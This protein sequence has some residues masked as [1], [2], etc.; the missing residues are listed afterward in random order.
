MRLDCEQR[1]FAQCITGVLGVLI[2]SYVFFF[3][4]TESYIDN[5]IMKR[6]TRS[7]SAL[8]RPRKDNSATDSPVL[9]L[10]SIYT[11]PHDI[12]KYI[13]TYISDRAR[14]CSVSVYWNELA[15]EVSRELSPVPLLWDGAMY[16]VEP[17]YS[18]LDHWTCTIHPDP[19]MDLHLA[20]RLIRTPCIYR[21]CA[22]G[23]YDIVKDLNVLTR[24]ICV[25]DDCLLM[26]I[27][28]DNITSRVDICFE[29]ACASGNTRIVD[30]Y[31]IKLEHLH[32]SEPAREEIL[33]RGFKR[34]AVHGYMPI[35]KMLFARIPRSYNGSVMKAIAHAYNHVE[36]IE[37]VLDHVN[38]WTIEALCGIARKMAA[39]DTM[40]NFLWLRQQVERTVSAYN[41]NDTCARLNNAF[42]VACGVANKHIDECPREYAFGVALGAVHADNV[43][44][45]KQMLPDSRREPANFLVQAG[46]CNSIA[47]T[48]YIFECG[49]VP[50][51][52]INAAL[53]AACNYTSNQ[54]A[55][56][57]FL[58]ANGATS[59]ASCHGSYYHGFIGR[60]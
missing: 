32:C 17:I 51:A 24:E 49:N 22:S 21:A 44:L 4:K 37:Y 41:S 11:L 18:D 47:V 57:R 59:C 40:D 48:R 16:K 53:T 1:S 13:F 23:N 39:C 43:E 38:I 34:A 42:W 29:M 25:H 5:N 12:L 14:I 58:A 10:G 3:A 36:V 56:A 30:L 20:K 46:E 28:D 50:V 54:N 52:A 27:H 55:T 9:V 8:D 33:L 19:Y 15:V 26:F 7:A 35:I 6:I 31:M 2:C 60:E 45:F